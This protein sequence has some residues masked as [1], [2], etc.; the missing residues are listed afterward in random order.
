MLTQALKQEIQQAYSRF[1]ESKNLKPRSGQKMMIAEIARTLGA[2]D[3]DAEGH[4]VNKA[5]ICAIEAG[6]GTGKTVAYALAVLP[7]AKALGKKVVI[8]TATVTLQEQII[9]R[10]LPDVLRHSGLSFRFALAKGRG[11]YLCLS[12]L[13]QRLQ[14]D[15]MQDGLFGVD[16][17]PSS[18]GIGEQKVKLYESMA[19][20]LL[21]SAWDGDRDSWTEKLEEEDWQPL[22][23]DRN[24]CAGRRCQHVAQCSFIKARDNLS[25]VDCVVANHDLVMAD[26]A[27]GGGAILPNPADTIYVFDEAHHLPDIALRHFTGQLRVHG[28]LHWLDQSIKTLQEINKNYARFTEL[29]DVLAVLPHV[30]LELKKYY[31]QLK[32]MVEQLVE[33]LHESLPENQ[34]QLPHYRFE[35]G[36]IPNDLSVMA[37]EFVKRF[38]PLMD[39]L[40]AAHD[41]IGS[42]LDSNQTGYSL[43]QLETLYADVGAMLNSAER[44]YGLWQAYSKTFDDIPDSRWIQLVESNGFLDYELAASPLLAAETLNRY[45]WHSC[46]GA[47]L[48]SATLTAL[49]EFR[50][51]RLHSGLPQ[52]AATAI[53]P[54][55]FDYA[56]KA[57]FVVPALQ[58]EPTQPQHSDEVAEKL[59]QLIDGHKGVLVLFAS[60]RQLD[61]VYEQLSSDMQSRV[62]SQTH[63][64]RQ[65]LLEEH[66]AR[67]D[68]GK[69][70][71]LFGMASLAEGVDL[72]GN[73]CT[74]V[75]IAKLPFAVPTD[76]VGAALDEWLRAQGKNAFFEVS[77]PDVSQKLVQACGRLIRS[78]NDSGQITLLD[79]RIL[80]KQYGRQLLNTLP[81]FQQIL[82]RG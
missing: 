28:S 8:S 54:S 64:N 2:I 57:K 48:T 42:T 65:K 74:H 56:N 41:L 38:Q 51:L 45:L 76:P 27:L 4:R 16:E 14:H 11:R 12:K 29:L 20:A 31:G 82:A 33:H 35:N 5:G 44:Q 62:L 58:Y 37:A 40:S 71:I 53:V 10:D 32:P 52:F 46:Y 19:K 39:E 15:V 23:A 66:I 67:I 70:S 1:L 69:Q 24:Q 26:L 72:P 73:Y 61:E 79:K 60:R 68:A 17:A 55:P 9:L 3:T 47:V 78:E 18:V 36:Q 43:N 34:G 59:D 30:L 63:M 75:I 80:T 22:T 49:G 50:R 6:T 77:L 25:A 81:P 7:I 21:T 13:D